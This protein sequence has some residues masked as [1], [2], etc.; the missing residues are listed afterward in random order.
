MVAMVEELRKAV[1]RMSHT[2]GEPPTFFEL[3]TALAWKFFALKKTDFAVVEVG[4][5]GRLDSTNV[6]S[7]TLTV[8]TSISFDHQQQLGNTLAQIASEKAGIIKSSIPV[9]SGVVPDE[10]ANVI[11][12]VAELSENIDVERA[13]AALARLQAEGDRDEDGQSALKR[14]ETRVQVAGIAKTVTTR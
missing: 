7:P 3:T 14:A 6:C 10:P 13:K 5:G 1:D 2:E 11:A 8:I 9:I 4:L 12:E